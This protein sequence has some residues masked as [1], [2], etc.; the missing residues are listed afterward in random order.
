MGVKF[1]LGRTFTA[2]LMD[3]H[4]KHNRRTMPWKG[5]PDPYK[6]WLSEIILQQTRVE[7]GLGYYL[8]FTTAYPDIFSLARAGDADVFKLW[9]GLGYYSRCRNLLHTARTVVQDYGGVFPA[10]YRQLVQLKG[11]G[12][13]TAA[14]IASFGFGL[15]YAVVDGN[16]IRVLSR[17]F[18]ENAPF[19]T[20]AGKKIFQGLADLVLDKHHPGAFNQAI[21]DFGATICKPALPLCEKCTLRKSCLAFKEQKVPDLPVKQKKAGKKDRFFAY[22]ILRMGDKIWIRERTGKDIWRHLHEFFLVELKASE[23]L[24]DFDPALFCREKEWQPVSVHS[25]PGTFSQA[26]THQ[27]IKSRFILADFLSAPPLP[28][29]G[30]WVSLHHLTNYAFPKTITRIISSPGIF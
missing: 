5:E 2:G 11:I 13:Y 24:L 14:A 26:L 25:I 22:L 29:D 28:M 18:L 3:W 12:P 4:R 1:D 15:P 21:M 8:R 20:P 7:Q 30:K 27:Q 17:F 6:I 9:E 23:S 16:V 19:D 10:D